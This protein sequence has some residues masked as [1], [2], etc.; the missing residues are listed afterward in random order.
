MNARIIAK[1]N[2]VSKV[3]HEYE[4]NGKEVKNT[5]YIISP[6]NHPTKGADRVVFRAIHHAGFKMGDVQHYLKSRCSFKVYKKLL[7]AIKVH[8]L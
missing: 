5:E 6:S 4:V 7:P 1:S 2:Y 3:C 8:T